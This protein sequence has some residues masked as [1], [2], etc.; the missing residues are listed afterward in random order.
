MKIS[1]AVMLAIAGLNTSRGC[2]RLDVIEPMEQVVIPTIRFTP[3]VLSLFSFNN[4][5]LAYP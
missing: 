2:T 1:P 3:E 4:L 5:H